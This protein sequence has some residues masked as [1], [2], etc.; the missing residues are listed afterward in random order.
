V[1]SIFFAFYTGDSYLNL[2]TLLGY[3]IALLINV[4]IIWGFVG[5]EY[6]LF[7]QFVKPPSTVLNYVKKLFQDHALR[8]VGHNPAGA[9]MILALLLGISITCFTGMELI[10]QQ[11]QGPLAKTIFE[12]SGDLFVSWH[13]YI[14]DFTLVLIVLHIQ[15]VIVMSE[16]NSENLIMA[17]I[18]GKKKKPQNVTNEEE[19]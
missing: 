4:R 9:V 11:G 13:R 19:T 5:T 6:A 18:T 10:A 7:T 15:G 16:L 3:G 8:Y 14:A 2:H 12:I 17:M 1:L